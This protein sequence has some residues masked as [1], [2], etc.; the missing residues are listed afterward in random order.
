MNRN[1][2]FT[3]NEFTGAHMVALILAFFAVIIGVNLFMAYHASRS[4]S[5]LIVANSYVAS[6][7]FNDVVGDIQAQRAHGWQQ[8]F[9]LAGGRVGFR[10]TDA[11]GSPLAL[12]AVSV[13]FRRAAHEREDHTIALAR[14]EGGRFEAP[15]RIA[16]GIWVVETHA[17]LGAGQSWRESFRIRVR[18]GALQP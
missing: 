3:R 8:D 13:T 4:W 6:Q 7:E 18:A 16:D 14:A 1:R 2:F 12:E 9:T 17:G 11:G 5:G 15:H 10:L